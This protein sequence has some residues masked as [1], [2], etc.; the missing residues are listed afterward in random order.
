MSI[1]VILSPAT[2]LCAWILCASLG[3]ASVLGT[4]D[5]ARD[6]D[7]FEAVFKSELRDLYPVDKYADLLGT[8]LSTAAI[9]KL[10]EQW[11]KE[12]AAGDA[13]AA[14]LRADPALLQMHV[15][16]RGVRA[17]EYLS[18]IVLEERADFAPCPLFIQK[19]AGA[20]EDYVAKTSASYSA[21][22]QKLAGR[23]D[24]LYAKPLALERR[25]AVPLV[26][27]V[28]LASTGD[29]RNYSGQSQRDA[30]F[31]DE[32][33]A[34]VGHG[35]AFGVDR[36]PTEARVRLLY[37]FVHALLDAH[38]PD[39]TPRGAYWFEY[40]LPTYLTYHTG[41]TPAALDTPELPRAWLE[42]LVK[43]VRDL[44]RRE[45]L[46]FPIAEMVGFPDAAEVSKRSKAMSKRL[47][48]A[49]A[50]DAELLECFRAQVVLSMHFL[51]DGHGEPSRA[52][53][54]RYLKARMTGAADRDAFL[55]AFDASAQAKLDADFYDYV[56]AKYAEAFPAQ[57]SD[58]GVV[59]GL[60][61]AR[62]A[63][64]TE[65]DAPAAT[66]VPA[67]APPPFDPRKLALKSDDVESQ[68]ALALAQAKSGD[69]DGAR[70]RLAPLA[71]RDAEV[72]REIERIDGLI[73]LRR[74]YFES[75]AAAG[76][77]WV[78]EF[79]GKKIVAPITKLEGGA[80]YLGE[81]R[82]GVA[83]I[84]LAS[85]PLLDVA[86][87]ADK[88][89]KQGA[90]PAWARSFAFLLCGE[91]K[92]DKLGKDDSAD[93]KALRADA[94]AMYP[95]LLRAA[96]AAAE[97]E[98]LAA[99]GVPTRASD[100]ERAVADAAALA[101]SHRDVPF[102]AVRLA[103]LRELARLALAVTFGEA[104]VAGVLAAPNRTT[105]DGRVIVTYDFASP[106]ELQDWLATTQVLRGF[107]K[108]NSKEKKDAEA[109]E[110]RVDGGDLA[111][112]GFGV[113]KHRLRLAGAF[114]I[115][116]DYQFVLVSS[117]DVS[118]PWF[119]VYMHCDGKESAIFS[120]PRGS[121]YVNDEKT[122]YRKQSIS[123]ESG[124]YLGTDYK[125]EIVG[126]G[127]TVTTHLDG[128]K[129]HEAAYGPRGSGLLGLMVRCETP[130]L[131]HRLEIEGTLDPAAKDELF[132]DW[133]RK[134]LAELGFE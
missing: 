107:F 119:D 7:G 32:L 6:L 71:S 45:T 9:E 20:A 53:F 41:L 10:R 2:R 132:A 74:G 43:T 104:G 35:D 130:L 44:E 85:V 95:A 131:V 52:A 100:A 77:K 113:L 88:K 19:P 29:F 108:A 122:S 31:D 125:L 48:I 80:V 86:K 109:L 67:P 13:E 114:R 42:L 8:E 49:E 124:L 54:L 129:M 58:R 66:P 115:A 76:T 14:R 92:W 75:L 24:A 111:L 99:A 133:S 97:L 27:V 103:D 18:K 126:D 46:L 50:N 121:L 94:Q 60:F 5:P 98:R 79:E 64:P 28:I 26:P 65:S 72:A 4:F 30:I 57:P 102:V 56:F 112:T 134:K 47:K 11:A 78:G 34:V 25:K 37:S 12:K 63:P 120:N 123:A 36:A 116:M 17:D 16:R 3:A 83:K 22:L 1:R 127:K 89:E 87:Q 51:Q 70:A 38:Q 128:E 90:A 81:N 59:E 55:A 33:G 40:G 68:H 82:Q 117:N 69:L 96:A 106:S 118:N 23:F 91:A 61:A 105:S 39:A 93:A 21:W 101:R 110:L 15:V 73:A 84:P 62:A